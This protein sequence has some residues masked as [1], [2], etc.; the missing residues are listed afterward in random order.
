DAAQEEYS[1]VRELLAAE[2]AEAREVVVALAERA[3]PR[4]A[5]HARV[6]AGLIQADLH[7]ALARHA[8]DLELAA[9]R[10]SDDLGVELRGARH[11]LLPRDACVPIDLTIGRDRRLLVISGPNG[12][13]KTAAMKT[14]GLAAALAHCGAHVPAAP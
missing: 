4:R 10:L 12:G 5:A 2:L 6:A 13:G 9:P 8:R 1:L 3:L 7:L 11:P 14:L